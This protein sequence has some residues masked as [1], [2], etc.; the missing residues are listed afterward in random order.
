MDDRHLTN[1]TKLKEK[2]TLGTT[3]IYVHRKINKFM[4][5]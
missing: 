4:H 1:I 2:K 3:A 5:T